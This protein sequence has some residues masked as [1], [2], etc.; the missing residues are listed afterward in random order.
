M[1]HRPFHSTD[2][3]LE[4]YRVKY[5]RDSASRFL[6]AHDLFAKTGSHFSGPCFV[7]AILPMQA[8]FLNCSC[9]GA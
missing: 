5:N 7:G 8:L 1:N 2:F 9:R 6:L 4:R 3:A